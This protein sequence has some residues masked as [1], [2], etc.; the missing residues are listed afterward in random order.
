MSKETQSPV[1]ERIK[2]LRQ[3]LGFSQRELAKEFRVS[4]SAVAHWESG[5]RQISGPVSKLIEIYENKSSWSKE[6]LKKKL[7][8]IASKKGQNDVR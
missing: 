2:S 1:Q 4:A 7:K 8:T 3:T 5:E 6:A